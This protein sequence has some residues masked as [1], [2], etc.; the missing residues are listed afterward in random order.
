MIT[1]QITDQKTGKDYI[2]NV[3]M[4]DAQ[5]L[6]RALREIVGDV[7]YQAQPGELITVPDMSIKL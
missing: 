4:H 6:Y 1:L 3:S 2:I 7:Q 5:K